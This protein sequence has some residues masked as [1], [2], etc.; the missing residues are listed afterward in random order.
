MVDIG[1]LKSPGRKAVRVRVPPA[2]PP[3]PPHR[4]LDIYGMAIGV[5]PAVSLSHE[6]LFDP[7]DE[8]PR[9]E[10]NRREEVKTVVLSMQKMKCTLKKACQGLLVVLHSIVSIVKENR[11]EKHVR[12]THVA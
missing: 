7:S 4:P 10:Q 2:P 6:C 8:L 11:T 1:D 9:T 12:T 5:K 3:S